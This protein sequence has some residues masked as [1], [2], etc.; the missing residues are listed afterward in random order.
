M[1]KLV[2]TSLEGKFYTFDMRVQHP[3][4]GFPSVTE[5]VSFIKNGYFQR[6]YTPLDNGYDYWLG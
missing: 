1:N 4:E 3:K 6:N 2:A 5:K